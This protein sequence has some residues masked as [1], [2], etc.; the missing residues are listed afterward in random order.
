VKVATATKKT[1]PSATTV[2]TT[3]GTPRRRRNQA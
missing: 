1:S 2:A 3:C